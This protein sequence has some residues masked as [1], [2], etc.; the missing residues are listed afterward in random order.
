MIHYNTN[1]FSTQTFLGSFTHSQQNLGEE[2]GAI[3]NKKDCE[4]ETLVMSLINQHSYIHIYGEAE[5]RTLQC[6]WSKV[7]LGL[8]KSQLLKL[9]TQTAWE[10]LYKEGVLRYKSLRLKTLVPQPQFD[11]CLSLWRG[12][13]RQHS[14]CSTH[15]TQRGVGSA[16]RRMWNSS[17]EDEMMRALE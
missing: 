17:L 13:S 1:T 3:F 11:K 8:G 2:T 10:C 7:N 16:Q 6:C 9:I 12:T 15:N 5:V 14:C 4:K